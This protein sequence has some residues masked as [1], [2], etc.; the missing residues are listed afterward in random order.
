MRKTKDFFLIHVLAILLVLFLVC[1]FAIV[2]KG[3]EFY[4]VIFHSCYDGDTCTVTIPYVTPFFGSKISV[5]VRNIDTPEIRGHCE[6]ESVLAKQIAV[7]VNEILRAGTVVHLKNI[8]RGKYF[9]IVADIYIDGV[10][11]GDLLLDKGYAVQYDGGTKTYN[12]CQ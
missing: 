10:S 1:A 6:K 5:R 4:N 8:E 11:L 3:E 12:W 7:Y 9:R 2:V